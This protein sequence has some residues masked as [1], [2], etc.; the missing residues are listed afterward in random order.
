MLIDIKTTH[1]LVD[2][3]D[4][5]IEVAFKGTGHPSQKLSEQQNP[6]KW[7]SWMSSHGCDGHCGTQEWRDAED[8]FFNNYIKYHT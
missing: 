1:W 6:G 4:G 5:R 3:G 8:Q 2:R 7:K